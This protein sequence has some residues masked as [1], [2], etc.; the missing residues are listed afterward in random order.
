MAPAHRHHQSPPAAAAAPPGRALQ[1]AEAPPAGPLEG[2]RCRRMQASWRCRTGCPPAGWGH[3]EEQPIQCLRPS[4]VRRCSRQLPHR[5][6]RRRRS[7]THLA[8]G[9][10]AL[11][12]QRPHLVGRLTAVIEQLVH[13][14]LLGVAAGR[15]RGLRRR[16]KARGQVGRRRGGGVRRGPC[17][18][19]QRDRRTEQ[20]AWVACTRRLRRCLLL[21]GSALAAAGSIWTAGGVDEPGCCCGQRRWA[22]NAVS[23]SAGR[24]RRT[25]RS[26]VRP[27]VAQMHDRSS[28]T[29]HQPDCKS[30]DARLRA[31]TFC[32]PHLRHSALRSAWRPQLDLHNHPVACTPRTARRH[33]SSSKA[34]ATPRS[35][36][37][38][39]SRSQGE[40]RGPPWMRCSAAQRRRRSLP[41]AAAAAAAAHPLAARCSPLQP[42]AAAMAQLTVHPVS[43]Y[44]FGS[45]PPKFEKD[46]SVAARMERLKEK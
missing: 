10:Q 37:P 13:A 40:Q 5:S 15:R 35:A 33:P 26:P 19:H 30:V 31:A 25:A 44:T 22:W 41:T 3:E 23:G 17:G 27:A 2:L 32:P 43:N 1:W 6:Y 8:L 18:A 46:S 4:R 28:L 34:A 20:S 21:T 16:R 29:A 7:A 36:S 42:A 24:A 11:P 14:G 45:R 38:T 12:L 9:L 39:A